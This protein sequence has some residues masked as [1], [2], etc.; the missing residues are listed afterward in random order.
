MDPF[1]KILHVRSER[2]QLCFPLVGLRESDRKVVIPIQVLRTG[3]PTLG[4]LDLTHDVREFLPELEFP[5]LEELGLVR[6][7]VPLHGKA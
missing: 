2:V 3:P 5:P 4:V 6:L 7:G 1:E